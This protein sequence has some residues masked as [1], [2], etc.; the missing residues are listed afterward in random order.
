[1]TCAPPCGEQ[2]RRS[3]ESA[4]P[5]CGPEE[6]A[7][8]LCDPSDPCP[9]RLPLV[10]QW[11]VRGC[12]EVLLSGS[13][14][15]WR[16]IRMQYCH[17][18]GDEEFM[19]I[20]NLPVGEHEYVFRVDGQW[21]V[22]SEQSTRHSA[23]TGGLVNYVVVNAGD[24]KAIEALDEDL[25]SGKEEDDSPPGSY[26]QE[27]PMYP[28]WPRGRPIAPPELPPYLSNV[29]LN[30]RT[31]E[32]YEPTLLPEPKHVMLNHLYALSIRDGV[33]VV[34]ATH[35]YRKKFVTSMLYKPI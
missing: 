15:R 23:V 10:I 34:S 31:P 2:R 5:A 26:T 6:S 25:T 24:F 28:A 13:F 9:R 22:D 35:R 19:A 17:I 29:I 32:T 8:Q 11:H 33:M 12:S 3:A 18:K 4:D 16:F 1:M 30:Q 27:I 14:C 20:V 21:L 7:W